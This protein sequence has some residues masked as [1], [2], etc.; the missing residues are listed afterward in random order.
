[1]GEIKKLRIELD[2]VQRKHTEELKIFCKTKNEEVQMFQAK[3]ADLQKRYTS[4][5]NEVR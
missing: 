5:K 3:Y 1:M 2:Y 4:F